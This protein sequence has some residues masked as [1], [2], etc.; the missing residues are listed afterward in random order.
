M[1]TN[2]L[3]ATVVATAEV[4]KGPGTDADSEESEDL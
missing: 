3:A 2:Y 1:G 4:I